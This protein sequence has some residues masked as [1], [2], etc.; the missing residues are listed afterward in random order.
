[1]IFSVVRNQILERRPMLRIRLSALSKVILLVLV[2]LGGERSS[3]GK[4]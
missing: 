2:R 3:G 1:M 4:S